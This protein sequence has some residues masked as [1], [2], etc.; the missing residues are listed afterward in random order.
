MTEQRTLSAIAREITRDWKNP[1]FGALPYLDA[2][3]GM[4][5]MTDNYFEDDAR[6]IVLY[7]LANAKSWRGEVAKRVKK[8]LR[9]MLK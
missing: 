8:E 2:M 4:G 9:G 1:Y 6:S 7:F 3:R 5:D